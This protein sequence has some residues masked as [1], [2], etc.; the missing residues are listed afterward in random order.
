M[1]FS[2]FRQE[3]RSFPPSLQYNNPTPLAQENPP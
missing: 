1:N 2:R 3:T